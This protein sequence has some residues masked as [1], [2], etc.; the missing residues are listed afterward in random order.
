MIDVSRTSPTTV[1][2]T[3][4]ENHKLKVRPIYCS[5]E[6]QITVNKCHPL[7]LARSRSIVGDH[8]HPISSIQ[9]DLPAALS[10]CC[11]WRLT[12]WTA[13]GASTSPYR[14]RRGIMAN[15]C[16]AAVHEQGKEVVLW[17][18]IDSS[19]SK[20]DVM[21]QRSIASVASCL[22]VWK[23]GVPTIGHRGCSD[24]ALDCLSKN[25]ENDIC[26]MAT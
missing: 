25:N 21:I 1:R 8:L 4:D 23:M 7:S 22:L 24:Q 15:G 13:A 11:Q 19:C 17:F 20:W 3:R 16:T 5:I 9:S 18:A 12:A 14:N 2:Y 6:E 10:I 26:S